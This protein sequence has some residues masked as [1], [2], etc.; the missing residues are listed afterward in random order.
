[1][2]GERYPALQNDLFI[3]FLQDDMNKEEL[4]V[5]LTEDVVKHDYP[6]NKQVFVTSGPSVKSNHADISTEESDHED[7]DSRIC[8]HV[9][10]TLKEGATTVLVRT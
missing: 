2:F 8:L 1:M 9:H 5:L 4:S 7:A 6:L 10:N 3:D